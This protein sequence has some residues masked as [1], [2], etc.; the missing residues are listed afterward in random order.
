[1]KSVDLLQI[2]LFTIHNFRPRRLVGRHDFLP[3]MR[4]LPLPEFSRIT[5]R[6]ALS[7]TLFRTQARYRQ[8]HLSIVLKL[9]WNDFVGLAGRFTTQNLSSYFIGNIFNVIRNDIVGSEILITAVGIVIPVPAARDDVVL[10]HWEIFL[11]DSFVIAVCASF[12]REK[13]S[14]LLILLH[15]GDDFRDRRFIVFLRVLLVEDAI[16][17]ATKS[18]AT[19][20]MFGVMTLHAVIKI[21][22]PIPAEL[23]E[24]TALR[25]DSYCRALIAKLS[26]IPPSAD[27]M[28]IL[29]TADVGAPRAV[30]KI[31][32]VITVTRVA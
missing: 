25:V 32:G 10:R 2:A 13:L 29:G 12:G 15:V 23:A 16:F 11:C 6:Q 27:V 1:M 21:R 22:V 18:D 8:I 19:E 14:P 4:T 28:A 9:L 20:T 26:R 31:G 17:R 7:V 3:A 30:L 24:C 5:L